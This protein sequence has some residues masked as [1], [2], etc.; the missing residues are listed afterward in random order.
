MWRN[1]CTIINFLI[2]P[3]RILPTVP[4]FIYQEKIIKYL[5]FI[6]L[7]AIIYYCGVVG[8]ICEL[9]REN[10]FFAQISPHPTFLSIITLYKAVQV[11]QKSRLIYPFYFP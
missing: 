2:E 11:Y 4:R 8:K 5:L 3:I 1:S 6:V 10:N 7:Y 9:S